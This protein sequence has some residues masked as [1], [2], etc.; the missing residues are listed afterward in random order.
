MKISHIEHVGIAV[1]SLEEAIPFYENMLG[2]KCYAVEEVADQK[3]KTAFFKCLPCKIHHQLHIS[4]FGKL[5][6][7]TASCDI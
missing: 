7:I 5:R 6:Q 3:V 1:T 2:L 4:A